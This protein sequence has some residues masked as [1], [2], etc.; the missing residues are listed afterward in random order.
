MRRVSLGGPGRAGGW[1][2]VTAP[3]GQEDGQQAHQRTGQNAAG[4]DAL[5]LPGWLCGYLC[6]QLGHNQRPAQCPKSAHVCGFWAAPGRRVAVPWAAPTERV[7]GT[8]SQLRA[9]LEDGQQA[10]KGTREGP[11][12]R[13]N[14]AALAQRLATAAIPNLCERV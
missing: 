9:V 6:V 5:R 4:P 12:G 8:W 14:T 10:T 13:A 1:Y 2:L 11:L 3:G 7:G